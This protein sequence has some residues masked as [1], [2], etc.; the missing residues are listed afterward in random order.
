MSDLT[1]ASINLPHKLL[2]YLDCLGVQKYIDNGMLTIE[3]AWD[4]SN[5]QANTL[6]CKAVQKY[7]DNGS[8]T[9]EQ[10]INFLGRKGVQKYLGNRKLTLENAIN[11][12][13]K[14]RK[15]LDYLPFQ[16]YIDNG[17]LVIER[18]INLARDDAWKMNQLSEFID[19]SMVD[20]ETVIDLS[21]EEVRPLARDLKK[22]LQKR[23]I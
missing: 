14:Q 11:L 5:G 12:S 13:P 1:P 23:R 17:K 3:Q 19:K 16:K 7:I 10:A 4:V 9:I 2:H 21:N 20:I 8:I 6:G 22:N 15:A 18:A